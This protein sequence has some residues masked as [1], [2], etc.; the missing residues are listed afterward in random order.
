MNSWT[1]NI[2]LTIKLPVFSLCVTKKRAFTCDKER[3]LV[4]A[5]ELY[6]TGQYPGIITIWLIVLVPT[7]QFTFVSIGVVMMLTN[8]FLLKNIHTWSTFKKNP[9]ILS[10]GDGLVKSKSLLYFFSFEKKFFNLLDCKD[11][12]VDIF[13]QLFYTKHVWIFSLFLLSGFFLA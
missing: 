10:W 5:S 8:I 2:Y 6:Q 9:I 3:T 4:M 11:K 7:L 1:L 12:L 13:D